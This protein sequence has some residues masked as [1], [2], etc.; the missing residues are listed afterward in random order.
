MSVL[1]RHCRLFGRDSKFKL[2]GGIV[3]WF[4]YRGRS[5]SLIRN[6][7]IYMCVSNYIPTA[8]IYNRFISRRHV[9]FGDASAGLDTDYS[10]D[11]TDQCA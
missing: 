9:S 3:R 10:V 8:I 7:S 6:N 11:G 5:Y 4:M 2:G 1:G